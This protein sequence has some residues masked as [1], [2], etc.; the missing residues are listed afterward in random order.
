MFPQHTQVSGF[1]LPMSEAGQERGSGVGGAG[2]RSGM[3]V[4]NGWALVLGQ[5]CEISKWKAPSTDI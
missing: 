4:E 3:K 5:E 2:K 1:S